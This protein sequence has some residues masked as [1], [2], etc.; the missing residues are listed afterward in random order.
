MYIW[1]HEVQCSIQVLLLPRVESDLASQ[2]PLLLLWSHKFPVPCEPSFGLSDVCLFLHTAISIAP[3][4]L[5]SCEDSKQGRKQ[6][7]SP[8]PQQDSEVSASRCTNTP[9]SSLS[10]HQWHTRTRPRSGQSRQHHPSRLCHP[11]PRQ[12]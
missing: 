11:A 6:E 12:G 5:A 1:G 2:F 9:Y 4:H 8:L 7:L 3:T 10:Q